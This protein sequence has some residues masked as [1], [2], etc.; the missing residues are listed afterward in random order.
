MLALWM[1]LSAQLACSPRAPTYDY[2]KEPDP[3]KSE[4]IIGNGDSLSINVWKN[5]ELSTSVVV[6]PDG[7]ITMPLVGDVRALGRTPSQLKV[8]LAGKVSQFVKLDA[9][10]ITVAVNEVRSYKFTV[11]GEVGRPG[12]IQ[13]S[14]YVTVTEAIMMA[15]GFTRFANPDKIVILRKGKDKKIRKIPIVFRHIE[16]GKRPDMNIVMIAGDSMQVP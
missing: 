10:Q 6:R 3:R 8:V 12:I 15:G 11:S 16:N 7:T 13:N 14:T 9:S 1:A 2:A 5:Q 4:Y